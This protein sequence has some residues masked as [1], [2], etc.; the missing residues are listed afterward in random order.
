MRAKEE[1]ELA[2]KAFGQESMALQ[3]DD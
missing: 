3:Q 2:M 1:F